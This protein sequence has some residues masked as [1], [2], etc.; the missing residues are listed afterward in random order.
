MYVTSNQV[1]CETRYDSQLL[2]AMYKDNIDFKSYF[3]VNPIS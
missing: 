2:Y 1:L 3:E